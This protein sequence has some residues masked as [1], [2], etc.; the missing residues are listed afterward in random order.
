MPNGRNIASTIRMVTGAVTIGISADGEISQEDED[1]QRH[2]QHDFE[3]RI[4]QAAV[5]R[6]R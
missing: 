3:Q 1:H 6:F 5:S 2:R 4:P